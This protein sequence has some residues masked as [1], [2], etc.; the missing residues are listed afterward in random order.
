MTASSPEVGHGGANCRV[1]LVG[2]LVDVTG[3]GDLAL[4]CRVDAVNLTA[5]EAL[6]FVYT[7]LLSQGIDTRML[8]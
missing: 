5:C 6:Q 3:V 2:V 7:E 1:V 4:G 8:Q